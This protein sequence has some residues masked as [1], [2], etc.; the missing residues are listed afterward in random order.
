VSL[1]QAG[2]G[3]PVVRAHNCIDNLREEVRKEMRERVSKVN[4]SHMVKS[5]NAGGTSNRS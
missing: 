4:L 2:S 1:R 5:G 3:N